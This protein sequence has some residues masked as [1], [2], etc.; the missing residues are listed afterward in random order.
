MSAPCLPSVSD[1]W[2]EQP[3][4]PLAELIE[5][6]VSSGFWTEQEETWP[7]QGAVT[8]STKDENPGFVPGICLRFTDSLLLCSPQST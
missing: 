4:Q 8:L 1:S 6:L 7:G 5:G 3:S 2:L